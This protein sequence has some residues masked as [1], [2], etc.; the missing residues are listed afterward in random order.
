MSDSGKASQYE[1]QQEYVG[2]T[3]S[4]EKNVLH[5]NG[6]NLLENREKFGETQRGLNS[7][8][9]AL[10][11]IGQSIGTG[12]F[13]GM[14]SPLTT[15]GS[16]SLFI[17]FVIYAV[18]VMWPLMQCVTEMC[19]WLPIKGSL[20]HFG[21]RFVDPAAGFAAGWTYFYTASMF[22]C[23]EFVATAGVISYW[24]DTTNP[25]A[26]IAVC[27]VT[28]L[29]VSLLPNK[30]YGETEYVSSI[31][32]VLLI[33]GL[34]LFAFIAMCG[35]NPHGD[36]F[37]FQHWKEGGLFREY[38]VEGATG[39]F[40]GFWNVL[41]YLAFACGGPDLIAMI[42]G[43]VKEPRRLLL[44][45]GKR[46]YVRIYLF[47]IG[48][49]F[50]MN[51]LCSSVN[52]EL[53]AARALGRSGAGA[54]P[55]VI[56]VESVGVRGISS[57]VNAVVMTSAYSCGIGFVFTASRTLYSLALGGYLPRIFLKCLPNGSPILCV[58]TVI[59]ISCLSFLSVS[60]R[61]ATVFNWFVNLATTGIL[62]VYIFIFICYFKFRALFKAQG[63]EWSELYYT[64]PF[65]CQPY[66]SY[67]G[68]FMVIIITFFNGFWIFFP[69]QFSA[70]N[71][72]TSYFAPVFAICAYVFWKVFKKTKLWSPLEA[73]ITTG[74]AEIDQE[75]LEFIEWK[76]DHPGLEN[77]NKFFK[78]MYKIG[79]VLY[80]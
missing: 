47:Y 49:I 29:A 37:G 23:V 30:L 43:E 24:D 48:G 36:A 62:S 61:S 79:D 58:L 45:C 4:N 39:K 22:V 8:H 66:V 27:L 40:L 2:D 41:I 21:A 76:L 26:Y 78:T 42:A 33:V 13:V 35:G 28:S 72:F 7:R 20:F 64:A 74:K 10:L 51:T 19:S 68:F 46:A 70:A 57:L 38:L 18:F 53:L 17:G 3:Y 80:G 67:F 5:S 50:F 32:K 6:F 11:A 77:K 71:L 44:V 59:L 14:S 16:L 65:N 56:G 69:G 31:L 55:W 60:E 52:E 9:I 1:I 63:H 73:D 34:M 12:L 54:S 75:E 25:G 15:S